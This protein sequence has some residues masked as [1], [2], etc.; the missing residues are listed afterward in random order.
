MRAT[1]L[2][3]LSPIPWWWAFWVRLT[4][5]VAR[6]GNV[7]VGPL[8]RLS[9]I[10]FARWAVVSRWPADR[11]TRR[12]RAAPRSLLFLTSF[13][14]SDIQYIEAFVRVV[15]GRINGLYGG[16]TGFPG[17]RRFGPVNDYIAAHNHTP[18]HFWIAHPEASTRMVSQALALARLYAAREAR[19]DATDAKE[20]AREWRGFLTASQGLL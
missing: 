6:V 14:G 3:V 1:P 2:T 9:F 17:P 4:W 8:R 7:V 10:H 5:P 16:A 12:D 19:L 18:D 15:P 13:D 11:Q 20:F